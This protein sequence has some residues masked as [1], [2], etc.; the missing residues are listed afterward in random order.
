[1]DTL[2]LTIDGT[3]LLAM[4]LVVFSVI[5]ELHY[6]MVE[7]RGVATVDLS[8]VN[9]LQPAKRGRKSVV[10]FLGHHHSAA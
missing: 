3:I 4:F 9:A 10:Y 8:T 7:R 1:M 6:A 5:Y 2:S